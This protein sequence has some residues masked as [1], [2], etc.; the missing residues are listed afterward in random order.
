MQHVE[1][2][3]AGQRRKVALFCGLLA[4]ANPAFAATLAHPNPPD[5]LLDGGPATA[6]AAR[7]DYA[8][9]I[10]VTGRPVAP[11]DLAETR[12]PVPDSIAIPL[13]QAS[14][15]A[16]LKPTGGDS[17]FVELDGKKVDKLVNPAPCR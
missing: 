2:N 13:A 17:A 8:A 5:P 9:G 3:V 4:C 14:G 11:A 12:T 10:D 15:G 7:P 6:C 1:L 16:R